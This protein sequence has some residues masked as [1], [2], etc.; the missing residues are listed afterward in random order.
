MGIMGSLWSG[1]ETGKSSA[2]DTPPR[3]GEDAGWGSRRSRAPQTSLS[4][5]LW[6]HSGVRRTVGS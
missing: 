2:G 3:Q 1:G 5:S 4:P 6:E